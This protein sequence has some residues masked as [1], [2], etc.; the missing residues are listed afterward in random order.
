MFMQLGPLKDNM[1]ITYEQITLEF[2]HTSAHSDVLANFAK[3]C[4]ASCDVPGIKAPSLQLI[5]ISASEKPLKACVTDPYSQN[6]SA[7]P[8]DNSSNTMAN[9]GK[10][11]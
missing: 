11:K 7:L 10:N 4:S 2:A 9:E 1:Q 5:V 3:Y 6:G 8:L